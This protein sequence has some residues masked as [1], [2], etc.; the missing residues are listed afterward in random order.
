MRYVSVIG[1]LAAAL[2]TACNGNLGGAS[3]AANGSFVRETS[4]HVTPNGPQT[5]LYVASRM[6][7]QVLG[8]KQSST[9]NVSPHVNIS[10]SNT[11]LNLPISVAIDAS[12]R[13]FVANSDTKVLRFAAG[14]NG[15][16]S[17][18]AVISGSKTKIGNVIGGIAIDASGHL[19]VANDRPT[20]EIHSN[21][22]CERERQRSA[23]AHNF[24][25][26]HQA[27]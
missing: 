16:V 14:S 25:S 26:R 7:S 23:V 19:W 15:N 9:G 21:S 13:I 6:G 3:P 8:F 10:G 11:D 24:G 12:G 2:L 18:T 22:W 4:Q 20:P 5:L 17:P 1:I 27:R